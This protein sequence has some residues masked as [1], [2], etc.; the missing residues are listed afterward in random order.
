MPRINPPAIL[1]AGSV[2]P[3]NLKIRVPANENTASTAKQ[4]QA[5]RMAMWR[6]LRRSA[7]GVMARNVGTA[8]MGSTRTKIEV[9]AIKAN[10]S[11]EDNP[12]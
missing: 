1:K 6:R 7:S 4:V 2:I 5:A 11:S 8:A 9:N 3:N 12:L 10:W